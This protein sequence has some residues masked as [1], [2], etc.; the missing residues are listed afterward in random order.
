MDRRT[1]GRASPWTSIT[2]VPRNASIAARMRTSAWPAPRT[3]SAPTA[4]PI[5]AGRYARPSPLKR[6]RLHRQDRREMRR[7]EGPGAT[8]VGAPP[9][10]AAR[11][12][13]VDAGR[14]EPV[15]GH[16]VAHHLVV[17]ASRKPVRELLPG[18]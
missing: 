3:S 14:I 10:L 2:K 4:S 5:A 1:Q 16:A 17:R 12:P 7:D 9:D 11:R 8:L 15:G 18:L 13:K 6:R